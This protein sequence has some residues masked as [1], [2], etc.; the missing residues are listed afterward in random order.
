[1]LRVVLI[2]LAWVVFA[3][4]TPDAARAGT[5]A[6]ASGDAPAGYAASSCAKS[7]GSSAVCSASGPDAYGIGRIICA[8]SG[9][10]DVQ[11][12]AVSE[13]GGSGAAIAVFGTKTNNVDFCCAY[14]LDSGV[15]A[16]QLYLTGGAAADTIAAYDPANPDTEFLDAL[17]SV[18]V[19]LFARAQAGADT[20]VG[21]PSTDSLYHDRLE[22]FEGADA[23]D[24]RDGNDLLF[25][26]DQIQLYADGG[27]T[28]DGGEGDDSIDGYQGADTCD[29]GW[30]E[31]EVDGGEGADS[32]DGGGGADILAGGSGNDV[33]YCGSE[34]DVVSGGTGNDTIYGESGDDILCSGTSGSSGGDQLFG[35]SGTD[36]LFSPI[37]AIVAGVGGEHCGHPSHGA[38]VF[39]YS[40]TLD[41]WLTPSSCP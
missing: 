19:T 22:G 4:A 11:I 10:S 3:I 38:G 5:H 28:L 30:G 39:G 18:S 24:G 21:S 31:D 2:A 20:V 7:S 13:Y 9:T 27:D 8:D 32:I 34:N 16:V 35:D 1:M 17:G 36:T 41:V 12:Y 15:T 25:G 33:I 6:C 26:G 40:C 37:S 14:D 23:I 29:G